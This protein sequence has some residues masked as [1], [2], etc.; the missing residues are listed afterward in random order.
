MV[1]EVV[2]DLQTR[3]SS[4]EFL[5]VRHQ[6]TFYSKE[7]TIVEKKKKKRVFGGMYFRFSEFRKFKKSFFLFLYLFYNLAN[8]AFM[9]ST[10][11]TTILRS[12]PLCRSLPQRRFS[13]HYGVHL[14]DGQNKKPYSMLYKWFWTWTSLTIYKI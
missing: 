5:I 7:T 8:D 1:G 13:T 11:T 12:Q 3:I 2:P 10:L 9:H 6:P 14:S 4:C